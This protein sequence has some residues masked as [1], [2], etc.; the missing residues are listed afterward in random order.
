ML[1][2]LIEAQGEPVSR[3]KFLDQVWGYEAYPSTR[4]IDNFV[5]ALRKKIHYD[6]T[7]EVANFSGERQ[8]LTIE[9]RVPV[10]RLRELRVEL[11]AELTTTGFTLDEDQGFLSWQVTLDAGEVRDLRLYYVLDMPRDFTWMGM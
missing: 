4:T 1:K 11:D 6:T 5:L 8:T 2:L 10:S 9:E 3:E 7:L